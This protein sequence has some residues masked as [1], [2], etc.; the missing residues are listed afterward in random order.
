M[1][2]VRLSLVVLVAVI[3]LALGSCGGSS[4]LG[5]CS[6]T[7]P[8]Y[9]CHGNDLYY[10]PAE[11]LGVEVVPELRERCAASGKACVDHLGIGSE[12]ACQVEDCANG[13]DDDSDGSTDCTDT[14]CTN[15]T[16]CL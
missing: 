2:T 15:T 7:E 6:G 10:C 3:S 12:P 13:K 11:G 4:S 9:L 5:N 14:D 16:D 1:A 8:F